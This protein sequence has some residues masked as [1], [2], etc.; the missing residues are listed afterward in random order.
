MSAVARAA[1][2]ATA[3]LRPFAPVGGTMCA[4]SPARNRFPYR[5]GAATK[6]R[7]GVIDFCSTGPL[8][9]DQPGTA[10]RV[11]QLLPDPVVR[12]AGDVLVGGHLEV[13][14]ADLRVCACCA[15]RTRCR[16]G[17]R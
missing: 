6:D 8:V 4:A 10:N 3:R 14:P 11:A 5:I 15:A 2:S 7:I 1:T 16:G 9:S 17:S 12:P 13:E